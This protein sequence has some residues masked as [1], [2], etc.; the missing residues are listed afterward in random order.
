MQEGEDLILRIEIAPAN[1]TGDLRVFVEVA[2][3]TDDHGPRA[4]IRCSFLTNYPQ[5]DRFSSEIAQ[6][7]D[8]ETSEAILEGR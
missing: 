3:D 4:R 7:M 1:S 6:L 5:I 2:D 8:G